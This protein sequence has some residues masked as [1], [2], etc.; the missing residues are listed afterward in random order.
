[1]WKVTASFGGILFLAL[2]AQAALRLTES[3][4]DP[5]IAARGFTGISES[6]ELPCLDFNPAFCAS[7]DEKVRIDASFGARVN[8]SA[9][10]AIDHWSRTRESF[11][12][13]HYRETLINTWD[14]LSRQTAIMDS[15][16]GV[17]VG[18]FALSWAPYNAGALVFGHD[19]VL[20]YGEVFLY[21]TSTLALGYG[22]RFTSFLE[23][24]KNYN[25]G[26]SAKFGTGHSERILANRY[27]NGTVETIKGVGQWVRLRVGGTVVLDTDRYLAFSGVFSDIPLYDDLPDPL[28]GLDDFD[29]QPGLAV[30][31]IQNGWSSLRGFYS[32][33]H[34]LRDENFWLKNHLGLEGSIGK[35]KMSVGM[36]DAMWTAGL[37]FTFPL[38][39]I[40]LASYGVEYS[41]LLLTATD[42]VYWFKVEI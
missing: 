13:S 8:D 12:S 2:P 18:S 4:W 15:G 40:S 29:F 9:L 26:V 1:M 22:H 25:L 36:H 10:D 19:P 17:R 35:F 41:K 3:Y 28:F 6:T 24:V 27:M 7:T 34:L 37:G 30:G 16:I 33:S 39:K 21:T 5:G 38:C 42:R 23:G 11:T 32:L 31:L 14:L 20:P